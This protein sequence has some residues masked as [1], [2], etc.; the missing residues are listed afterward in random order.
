M[1]APAGLN[2]AGRAAWDRA[3]ATLT[4]PER[5]RFADV[6]ASYAHEVDMAAR[7]RAAWK[8]AKFAASSDL[9]ASIRAC[10]RTIAHLARALRLTPASAAQTGIPGRPIGA[11]SAPDR[12][13]AAGEPGAEIER[14]AGAPPRIVRVK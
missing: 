8:R 5:E 9:V 2:A 1:K 14:P 11:V 7:L 3:M 4:E 10:D 6:A 13:A 12:K